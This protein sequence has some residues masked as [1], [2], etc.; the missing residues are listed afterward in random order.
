MFHVSSE[1]MEGMAAGAGHCDKSSSQENEDKT[2][3]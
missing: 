2:L 1:A 3:I